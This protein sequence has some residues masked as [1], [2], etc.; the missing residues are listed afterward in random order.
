VFAVDQKT[1]ALSALGHQSTKGKTPRHFAIDPKGKWLLAENKDSDSIVVF[2]IDQKS[3][4]LSGTGNTIEVGKPVCIVF[5][6]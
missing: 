4:M 3:G 1:G 2:G 5:A 6:Q